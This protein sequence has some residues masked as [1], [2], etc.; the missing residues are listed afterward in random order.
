MTGA[1]WEASFND[2]SVASEAERIAGAHIFRERCSGCHRIDGSGGPHAPSLSRSGYYHGDSDLAIYQVLR[3]D[4]PWTAMRGAALT[5]R[6]PLHVIAYLRALQA[7]SSEGPHTPS[8]ALG[9]PR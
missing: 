3:H 4:V 6:E 7:H 1:A 2:R 8:L 5:T 9:Y